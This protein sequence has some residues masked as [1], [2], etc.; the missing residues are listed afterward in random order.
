MNKTDKKTWKDK[1]TDKDKKILELLDFIES[2]EVDDN[3]NIDTKAVL[4]SRENSVKDLRKLSAEEVY[5]KIKDKLELI[6]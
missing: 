5:L 3:F 2:G 1:I 4:T 6:N